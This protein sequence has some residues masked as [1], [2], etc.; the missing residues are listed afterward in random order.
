MEIRRLAIGAAALAFIVLDPALGARGPQAQGRELVADAAERRDLEALR[1]LLKQGADPNAAQPDGA[2]ALHWAVYW[3]DHQAVDILV[4]AGAKPDA[5]NDLGVFPLSL[6]CANGSAPMA[7]R[8]LEAGASV[9][10]ALPS[11]E[12]PLMTC[13]RTGAADTVRL[14]AER[15]GDVNARESHRGQTALMWAAGG[16]HP[17]AVKALLERGAD[18]NAASTAGFTPLMF[19]AREG[20]PESARLLLAAGAKIDATTPAGENALLVAAASVS[21]VTARD[22][23]VIPEPSGHEAVA[24]LL[25]DRGSNVNQADTFGMTALHHSVETGKTELLE[26]LI[27]HRAFLDARLTQG[28]PFRRA[29]YVSRAGYAGATPFWLAAMYGDVETM[30]VLVAAGADWRLP[31]RNGT[32]PL[33]VA[34]GLGQTDSRIVPEPKLLE[35]VKYLVSLGGDVNDANTAGQTAMHGAAGISGHSIIGYLASKGANLEAKDKR[36]STPIDVTHIIQRPRPETEAVIR[37]LLQQQ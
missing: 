32:T 35:A 7:K 5:V 14:L 12:S 30:K 3:D 11:G 33:M 27:A 26:T 18:V 34:A 31:S 19:A 25:V 23:R 9:R 10:T 29:D 16:N 28:L 15:G 37:K 13:A 8:L 22:Y 21:G 24:M 36:G 20:D 2:T 4:R 1:T 6:A 17:D